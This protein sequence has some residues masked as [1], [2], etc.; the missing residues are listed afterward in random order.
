METLI[1]VAHGAEVFV[2]VGLHGLRW[3]TADGL[4]WTD[5]QQGDEGEH[6]NAIVWTGDRFVAFGQGAT[7]TSTDVAKW[8][9]H[10][11]RD[12]PTAVCYRGGTFLGCRSK[13]RLRPAATASPG[14]KSPGS[15]AILRPWPPGRSAERR[16][17]R[18]IRPT[19]A[20]PK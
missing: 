10:P 7:F 16:W 9:R 17:L 12:A 6:L 1:D 15:I 3:R 4:E 20:A 13:G 8:E 11:N 18:S 2:G 14:R 5:R 19:R